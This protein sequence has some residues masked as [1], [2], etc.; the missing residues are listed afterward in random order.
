MRNPARTPFAAVFYNE[1]LL[2]SKRVV[3]YAL[4]VLFSAHAVLWWGWSAAAQYG[5]A[6]NGD[7][8]IVRNFQG[9]SFLLGLPIF[10]AV[11]MG[12]PVIRDVRAGIEPLIFSK[13][14]SRASYLLGKFFGNFFVLVCCQS[15]FALT[16][17]LL[18]WFPMS[19]LVV[20]PVR[21]FPY[22]KHFLLLVVVSHLLLAAVYFTVGTLTR[23]AKIVYV[24]AGSFYPLYIA[25]QVL[26][27]KLLPER[28]RVA[29]DPMLMSA[30]SIPR[31]L[32]EDAASV[33]RIVVTYSPDMIANRLL[34]LLFAA[35][36]LTFLYARFV[37]PAR[38]HKR[39]D[40][41]SGATM[42]NLS[43]AAEWLDAGES[44]HTARD[45][46]LAE[47]APAAE[48][49]PLPVVNTAG[50]EFQTNLKKLMAALMLEF[51]LLRAERGLVLIV[52]LVVFL[53][54]LE[55]TFYA[56][57]ADI[58][59]SATYASSTAQSVS[60]F[61]YAITIFYTGEAMHRD[62]EL[63]VEPLLWSAPVPNYVLL[64]AKFLAPVVLSLLLVALVGLTANVVQVYRGHEPI[65]VK[66]YLLIYTLIL[67]PSV[68]FI[69]AA[70][71]LANVLLRDKYLAYAASIATGGGLFYLYSQG[72]NHW[73]YNPVL[74]QL[75][76][77][78]DLNG[79]GSNRAL[80]VT[81]RIYW[82]AIAAACLSLALV[83]LRRKSTSGLRGDKR[84]SSWGWAALTLV[85][86]IA[87]AVAAGY[88]IVSTAR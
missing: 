57:N 84:G 33:N 59:Y 54:T 25:Y 66:A 29:L 63:R 87:I 85:V 20:H 76:T 28:W 55:V 56:V 30:G 47:L 79:A 78:A 2:N 70:S 39:A 65:E 82:L 69:T 24:A 88:V 5:W 72:Y 81:H 12:D 6:T 18:Q 49:A 41:R 77:Y 40:D 7:F 73:L 61:L 74:Y 38:L 9:F 43:P 37:R 16:M 75:W 14:I 34:M 58:S 15:A 45:E 17:L 64:L 71:V 50:E 35:A 60:L 68:V 1:L 4:M 42:L 26:V 86:S 51:R 46:V 52:P 67:I 3:P 36:C 62:R 23:N 8:N 19:R 80:I 31:P 22:F 10:T 21:V 83:C 44:S 11:I 27:L 48:K 32:W 53:S 13:P